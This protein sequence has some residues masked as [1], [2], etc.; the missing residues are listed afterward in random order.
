[1]SEQ[2]QKRFVFFSTLGAAEVDDF[3]RFC[4]RRSVT[5]GE[6]LWQEGD[7]DNYAAFIV[8]GRIGIKKRT[9]FA[10]E[11]VIVGTYGSGSVAGELCLLTENTRSVTAEALED[12]ELVLLQS[13]RF[14][15]LISRHP[16][17]AL[18]LLK[19]I[20]TTTCGRLRKS[21]E[22]IASIF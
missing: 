6:V 1:M 4:E 3:L 10:K 11:Q 14:E 7:S 20:F 21:Y 15:D 16:Q 8:S 9:E 19:H 2:L 12:G 5:A 18:K 22:R 13:T 17:L